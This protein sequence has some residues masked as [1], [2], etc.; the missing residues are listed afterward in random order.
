MASNNSIVIFLFI[1]VTV[2]G[3]WF[4]VGSLLNIGLV[5][6]FIIYLPY[7]RYTA[8]H[9]SQ[10]ANIGIALTISLLIGYIWERHKR[11]MFL[12]HSQMNKLLNIFSHDMVSPFNSL[13]GLLKLNETKAVSKYEFGNYID[14]IKRST[15]SNILL[16]QNL[17]KWS[18]SQLEG[19]KPQIEI[20]N[21][22]ELIKDGIELLGEMARQK[23]IEVRYRP[24][25]LNCEGDAEM[26]R[27]IIRNTLSNALKFSNPHNAVELKLRLNTKFA[28]IEIKDYGVG[29]T[30][31]DVERLSW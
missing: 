17:V 14:D 28:L 9:I 18:K 5:T 13:L 20:V 7:S 11:V 24:I 12:Q 22:N 19:F 2:S 8:F 6:L 3:L 26:I 10:I 31:E 23:N 25:E 29:M 15:S 21:L 27:L 16:L 1:T 4:H 30:Q